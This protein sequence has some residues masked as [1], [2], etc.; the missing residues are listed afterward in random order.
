MY[1]KVIS[2]IAAV[3]LLVGGVSACSLLGGAPTP[4]PTPAPSPQPPQVAVAEVVV[5]PVQHT[6][7]AFQ[8]GG[9]LA[10]I[11]VEAGHAVKAGQLLAEL[12]DSIYQAGL[13]QAE[14]GMA[15][16]Q[17]NL[18]NVLAPATPAQIEQA[19]AALNQAQAALDQLLAGPTEQDIAVV[20]AQVTQAQDQLNQ[21][22]A[23]ATEQDKQAAAAQMLEAEA[24]VRI[25][26]ANYDKN[27]YGEPQVAEP[28]GIA[29]EQATLAYDAARANYEK[30]ANGPTSQQIAVAR[31]GVQIAQASLDKV[32]AGATPDQIAQ[33]MAMV[34]SAK[35]GL[36]RLLTGA[37][38]EQVAVAQAGVK[39]AQ[40]QVQMAQA[41]LAQTRLVAP[42]EGTI[43]ARQVDVGQTLAPSSPAFSL[44]DISRWQVQTD[45]LSQIDIINV[46]EGADVSIKLNALPG[47]EFKGQVVRITPQ[48]QTQAGDVVY[49]VLIDFVSGDTSRLRW[50]MT[51]FAHIQAAPQS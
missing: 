27:V 44:G 26:Q 14:A 22:L 24:N 35:A 10:A 19:Q 49:K 13:A 12:D 4:Q 8:V 43:G 30:V 45:N 15:Q 39:S 28:Y 5:V 7:L 34:E 42:F 21:V 48:S 1:L 6:Q 25:A 11:H 32:L 33:S 29:L 2:L 9:R 37:T 3:A 40:K 41:Q 23:G 36:N 17:A 50:G 20:R 47:E 51:G 16:A 31:S 18:N 38:E 46:R